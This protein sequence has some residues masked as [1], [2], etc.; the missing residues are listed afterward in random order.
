LLLVV[1]SVR[2]PGL[3]LRAVERSGNE[4]LMEGVLVMIARLTDGVE[5][6]DE[7]ACRRRDVTAARVSACESVRSDTP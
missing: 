5:P 2:D 7:V 1:V 6:V 3:D 4:T